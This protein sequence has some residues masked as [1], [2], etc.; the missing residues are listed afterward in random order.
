MD[1][2]KKHDE[3]KSELKSTLVALIQFHKEKCE[4]L[5]CNLRLTAF[6]EIFS[7]L[8]I[9]LTSEELGIVLPKRF[10]KETTTT[11]YKYVDAK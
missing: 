6:L 5:E 8:D 11:R 3:I 7:R 9:E 2:N 10:S 1:E 4:D